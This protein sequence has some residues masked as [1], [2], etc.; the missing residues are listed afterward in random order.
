MSN[1]D[2]FLLTLTRWSFFGLYI[3]CSEDGSLQ[4][5]KFLKFR[6]HIGGTQFRIQS[7]NNANFLLNDIFF[8]QFLG[9]FSSSLRK[10]GNMSITS[11][12]KKKESGGKTSHKKNMEKLNQTA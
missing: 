4:L 9:E 5:C 1:F 6:D 3:K 7:K 2:F 11:Q 8:P 12:L 10:W